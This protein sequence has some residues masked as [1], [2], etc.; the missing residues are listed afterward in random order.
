M[1]NIHMFVTQG[2]IKDKGDK[3]VT[4]MDA[5][6]STETEYGDENVTIEWHGVP[7]DKQKE[8]YNKVQVRR[9]GSPPYS[10][11][12][13]ETCC[14]NKIKTN[15]QTDNA[16][17]STKDQLGPR[18][19]DI[20]HSINKNTNLYTIYDM[21]YVIPN[22]CGRQYTCIDAFRNACQLSCQPPNGCKSYTTTNY[23]QMMF[24]NS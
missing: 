20:C 1:G 4:K 17:V 7:P 9:G 23:E 6:T 3:D 10:T 11:E 12:D 2:I 15:E 13:N 14:L 18:N 24:T 8:L 5:Y 22:I 16:S 19:D 21:Y